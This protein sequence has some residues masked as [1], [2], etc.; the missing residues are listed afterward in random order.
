MAY[1]MV[2]ALAGAAHAEIRTLTLR[3]ALDLTLEQA[4]EVLLS[5][6]EEQKAQQR[7]RLARDPFVP[8][9]V[10]GSGLAYT[11]GFPMSIEGSAPSII[12]A[13]AIASVYNLPQKY[14]LAQAKEEARTAA[15]DG[16]SR[17]EQ[18]VSEVVA[19]FLDAERLGK[20]SETARR[21]VDSAQR[22]EEAV[23][24]R[25]AEG[26]E[27]PIEGKRSALEVARARQ[28]A[29]ALEADAAHAESSLA[30]VLGLDGDTRA[31]PAGEDRV[32]PELPP[33]AD[34]AVTQALK[35]NRQIRSL[36]SALLAKSLQVRSHRAERWPKFDLVAQYGL[37][38]RFNNYE[39]FFQRFQ[40]HNGQVGVSIQVPLLLGPA[41]SA[42]AEA[43]EAEAARLRIEVNHTRRRISVETRRAYDVLR[44]VE[45][46]RQVARLDLDV[47]RDDLSVAL[48]RLE[49]GR[50][51]LQQVEQ[52]R[53]SENEKWLAWI[54]A[55]YVVERARYDL[56]SRTGTL[57]TLA[58]PK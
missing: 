46:A 27:L 40:R 36:E 5:R 42:Q 19:L 57:I 10:A 16:Q 21:Q 13:R 47:A 50:A 1:W 45:S 24:A 26:R 30:M 4:P 3:Q 51:T 18:A 11:N 39:E 48:A 44:T 20:M 6:I 33:S 14:A 9:I 22:S 15:L 55:H 41:S 56:L 32:A 54:D 52:L 38:S 23:R 35:D 28:R 7:V 53:R 2:L 43:A 34:V 17:R 58:T 37:F 8:K 49:E 25:V 31:R 29:E 12:Q